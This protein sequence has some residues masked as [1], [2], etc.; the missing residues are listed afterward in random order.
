MIIAAARDPSSSCTSP[1]QGEVGAKRRVTGW[2]RAAKPD[3]ARLAG[4]APSPRTSPRWGEGVE[5]A[6]L[7]RAGMAL[8]LLLALALPLAGCGKK[9]E[10]SPP[11][12]EKNTYPRVY[13]RE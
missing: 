4:A 10:P 7:C 13:P 12:D 3:T 8:V 1:L 6:R 5:R 11:P 9:S 2:R